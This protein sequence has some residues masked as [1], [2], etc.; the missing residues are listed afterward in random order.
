ME[1]GVGNAKISLE[2][3]E[4]TFLNIP[5]SVVMDI[6]VVRGTYDDP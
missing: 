1:F 5:P 2:N 6:G 4:A 3:F